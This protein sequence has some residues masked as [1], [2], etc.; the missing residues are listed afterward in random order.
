M[1]SNDASDKAAAIAIKNKGNTAFAAHD[2]PTA[3]DYYT[4]AIEKYD[5]EPSFYCNRAQANLKLEAYGYA[6]VDAT[7]A[8]EL[9][10]NY[11]KVST[12][13]MGGYLVVELVV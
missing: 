7:K 13:G 10:P 3:V 5:A 6:I 11:V 1:A 2:W 12:R 8:I 9:D 4:K